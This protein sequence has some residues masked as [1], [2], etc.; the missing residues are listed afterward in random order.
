MTWVYRRARQGDGYLYVVGYYAPVN[1]DSMTDYIWEPVQDFTIESD[2]RKLV[3][4][5]NGGAVLVSNP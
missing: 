4:Y 5:L 2:A 1:R 3:N